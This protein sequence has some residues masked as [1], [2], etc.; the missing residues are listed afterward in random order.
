MMKAAQAR[1]K[2]KVL[3]RN[4]NVLTVFAIVTELC[5]SRPLLTNSE[6]CLSDSQG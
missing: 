4:V 3:T 6:S 1:Y 5:N 2:Y